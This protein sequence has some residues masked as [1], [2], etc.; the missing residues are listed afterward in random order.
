M[1]MSLLTGLGFLLFATLILRAASVP[2]SAQ[3]RISLGLFFVLYCNLAIT[4]YLWIQAPKEIQMVSYFLFGTG[5]FLFTVESVGYF[6]KKNQLLPENLSLFKKYRKGV[7]QEIILACQSL[8]EAKLGALMVLERKQNLD[9]WYQKGISLNAEIS[10]ELIFSVFTPPGA[11][12]DGAALFQK[13]RLTACAV[14]VPLTSNSRLPKHLGTR[15]RAAV[16]FSEVTDGLCLVVSEETGSV[17]IADR[18]VLN[19]DIPLSLLPEALERA[20]RFKRQKRKA[21]F[22]ARQTAEV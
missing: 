8:A 17:S 12:H 21:G 6:L 20:L 22:P 5:A 15:H 2:A 1:D 13:D 14:I 18:G 16:G 7:Y 10:K 9:S 11:L 19:Y 4:H 3:A